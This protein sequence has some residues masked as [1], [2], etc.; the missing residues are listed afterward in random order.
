MRNWLATS[1]RRLIAVVAV[2]LIIGISLRGYKALAPSYAVVLCM[3]MTPELTTWSHTQSAS[4][5]QLCTIL[6]GTFA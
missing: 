6:C 5:T 1:S 3:K 2:A 4:G